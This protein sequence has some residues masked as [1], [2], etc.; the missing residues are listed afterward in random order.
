ML[1]IVKK[2]LRA[3]VMI[4]VA[5]ALVV[6]GVAAAQ[7][8]S[9]AGS[10]AAGGSLS[11]PGPPPLMGPPMK[12]LT[13]AEFH[14]QK[15]G[16]EEVLRLD[17]GKISSVGASSITLIENDGNSVTIALNEGTKVLA[18]PGK[19]ETIGDLSAGETVLVSA[20]VGAEAKA[21]MVPPSGEALKGSPPAGAPSGPP[22][23]G[24]N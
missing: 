16:Q 14:L 15:N 10:G 21:I 8:E 19:S 20:P 11:H 2:Q 18:G 24:G 17:Q 3:I 4:G 13:Y 23:V 1:K 6:G 7:G 22:P 9:Q 12:G 5:S